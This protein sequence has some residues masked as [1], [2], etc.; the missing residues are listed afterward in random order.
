MYGA[1]AK[2]DEVVCAHNMFKQKRV[3]PILQATVTLCQLE[4]V[5]NLKTKTSKK[6][7]QAQ[8]IDKI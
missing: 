3:K 6:S 1:S 5:F 7:V 8:I 2:M 4:I